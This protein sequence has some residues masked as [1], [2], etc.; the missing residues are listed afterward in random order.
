M[1]VY[2]LKFKYEF[3]D[4]DKNSHIPTIISMKPNPNEILFLALWTEF[5]NL[6]LKLGMYI[7]IKKNG[8]PLPIAKKTTINNFEIIGS[9]SISDHT[10]TKI[11]E[12]QGAAIIVYNVPIRKLDK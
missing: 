10:N 8:I 11:P 1:T 3:G 12:A 5:I 4:S 7:L 9:R 6:E 2:Q